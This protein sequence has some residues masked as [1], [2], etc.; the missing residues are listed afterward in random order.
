MNAKLTR[1]KEETTN[2]LLSS[3]TEEN[4]QQFHSAF[5][6]LHAVDQAAFFLGLD[7]WYRQKVLQ[8][9]QPREFA[10]LFQEMNLE[11]RRLIM[12]S[13][14]VKYVSELLNSMLPKE[15]AVFLR[16]ISERKAISLLESMESGAR[17]KVERLLKYPVNA[18]G[19]ITNTIFSSVYVTD[20]VEKVLNSL[21]HSTEEGHVNYLFVTDHD[22]HLI[23]SVSM[24][25]LLR[26]PLNIEINEIMNR[27]IFSIEE[28]AGQ[29]KAAE[30]I[31]KYDL[32]VLPVTDAHGVMIGIITV[33]DVLDLLEERMEQR[34]HHIAGIKKGLFLASD[35]FRSVSQ[36]LP[37]LIGLTAVGFVMA[38]LTAPYIASLEQ[39]VLLG[40]FIPVILGM[41]G[42]SGIQSLSVVIRKMTLS[43]LKSKERWNLLAK[44]AGIG[45]MTGVVCGLVASLLA[46]LLFGSKPLFGLIV[47]IALSISILFGTITGAA[48]PLIVER[49]KIDPAV[50]SGPVVTT[51]N[52]ILALFVYYGVAALILT[53]TAS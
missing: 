6:N 4:S 12:P 36:R 27:N 40:L 37:W 11:D 7:E 31:K 10:G 35:N 32:H 47:G 9:L 8:Y 2:L 42:N 21:R 30:I 33:D 20:T 1:R 50:A 49:F 18:V 5:M 22:L 23:G 24:R 52:D 34:I 48:L 14:D 46:V 45:V 3:L 16:H 39:F 26:A 25:E 28:H 53:F 17:T 15:T 41:S 43:P 51:I 38:R 19:A 13:L 29:A 44:E